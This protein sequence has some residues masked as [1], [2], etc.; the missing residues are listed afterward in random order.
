MTYMWPHINIVE[1]VVEQKK[2]SEII[3]LPTLFS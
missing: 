1:L 2:N 3:N